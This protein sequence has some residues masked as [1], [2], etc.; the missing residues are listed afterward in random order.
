MLRYKINFIHETDG[1]YDRH[2][3]FYDYDGDV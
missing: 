3:E 2:V 1:T